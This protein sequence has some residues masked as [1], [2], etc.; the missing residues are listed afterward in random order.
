MEEKARLYA[1]MKRGDVEDTEDKHMVDFDRKWAE[2]EDAG[3]E[4]SSSSDDDDAGSEPEET[5]EY[6]DEFGRTRRGTR[7]E[8]AREERRRKSAMAD[9]PDRFTARPAAPSSIIYGDTVQA[10][11]FNPDEPIAVQM[12][13][14]AAKRDREATPPEEVHFDGRSEVRTKGVGFFQFS[15][16][17]GERERQMEGLERE[18]METERAR[19]ERERRMEER[20]REVEERRKVIREK[21]GKGKAERFLEGLMGE[22]GDGGG[23]QER[24]GGEDT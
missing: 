23:G 6:T 17:R 14:L 18:R 7:A 24:D 5:V 9:A 12:A 10:A 13:E 2:R 8:A 1:A 20:R 3:G 15:G 22:L 21:R 19:G 11:A 16:E 4:T